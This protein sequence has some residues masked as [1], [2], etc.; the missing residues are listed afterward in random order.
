MEQCITKMDKKIKQN[1]MSL[2][3]FGSVF[4]IDTQDFEGFG[5]VLSDLD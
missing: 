4:R 5:L 2:E 1:S 3:V